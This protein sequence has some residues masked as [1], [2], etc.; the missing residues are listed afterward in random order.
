MGGYGLRTG[1]RHAA[2]VDP[3]GLHQQA[4]VLATGDAFAVATLFAG[5]V[6][7]IGFF[8][9]AVRVAREQQK[10]ARMWQGVNR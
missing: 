5:P 1:G 3:F 7:R 8:L 6:L 10:Q 4:A 9:T 2:A